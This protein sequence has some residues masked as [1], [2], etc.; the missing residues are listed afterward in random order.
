MKITLA[1]NSKRAAWDSYVKS[2]PDASPYHL[3]A[4]KMAVEK[5]YGHRGYY[6]VAEENGGISG[7]LPLIHL[8]PPLGR[9]ELVGLPYCDIGSALYCSD[10]A[11]EKLVREAVSIGRSIRVSRIEL[12]GEM[13][14]GLD[15]ANLGCQVR[16]FSN[17]VRMI[18]EL[19]GSSDKLWAAFKAKLRSQIRKAE[20][21]GLSFSWCAAQSIEDFY[22]VFSVNMRD[23]G[24]PVHDLKFFSAILEFYGGDA[25]IGVV[26][27][28][29]KPVGAGLIIRDGGKVSI[30]WAS[31]LCAYDRLAPNMLLYWN[32][33]KFSA[34]LGCEKFDFGRSTPDEGTF[35]FKSQWGAVPRPLYWHRIILNGQEN[36]AAS[37]SPSSARAGFERLW[38]KMPLSL[39]NFL[40][41]S[42]RKYISL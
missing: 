15:P 33:L 17:K 14:G 34:D 22:S 9:G 39:A 13:N 3:F 31:T 7:V 19:P 5:A 8:K 37:A 38:R 1:D 42:I 4:W 40:G 29:D 36:S 10:A 27:D 16:T 26:R 18:C 12:R 2:R 32:I 21:N 23:L 25:R 28:G 24:S 30:P 6:L 35:R 20:K 11:G 41:P